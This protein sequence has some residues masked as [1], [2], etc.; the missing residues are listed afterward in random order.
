MNQGG[1]ADKVFI[2]PWQIFCQGRFSFFE[3]EG[4]IYEPE[5]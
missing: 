1:T 4:I 2:R 5:C 3:M